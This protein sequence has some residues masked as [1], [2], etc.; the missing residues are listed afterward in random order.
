MD[1]YFY[2]PDDQLIEGEVESGRLYKEEDF[3]RIIEI[4][5]RERKRV[6][7]FMEQINQQEKTLVFCASQIHALAVRDLINQI[8]TSETRTTATALP[9]TTA[10]WGSSTSATFRTTRKPSRRS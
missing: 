5:Q 7:I 3:N 6:E 9:Q 4:K 8:K 1:E 2:T 10:N